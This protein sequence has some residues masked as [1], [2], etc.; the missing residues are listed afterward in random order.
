[1]KP[2]RHL[3]HKIL[4]VSR[5]YPIIRMVCNSNSLLSMTAAYHHKNCHNSRNEIFLSWI[6]SCH[7]VR[8]KKLKVKS[9]IWILLRRLFFHH[10]LRLTF[11]SRV[12]TGKSRLTEMEIFD[13]FLIWH[14]PLHMQTGILFTWKPLTE[15]FTSLHI[16]SFV[17]NTSKHVKIVF[18]HF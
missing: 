2:Y 8:E 12:I 7:M 6:I 3:N 18:M 14:M 4:N 11:C 10:L 17:L 16:F 15:K 9:S 5:K 13:F 1:M